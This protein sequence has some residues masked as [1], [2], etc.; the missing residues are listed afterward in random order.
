MPLAI[1]GIVSF[2]GIPKSETNTNDNPPIK[3]TV[4][5]VIQKGPK[6]DLVYLS[7]I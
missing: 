2:K 5:R 7:L 6:K 4:L 1:Q 3:I